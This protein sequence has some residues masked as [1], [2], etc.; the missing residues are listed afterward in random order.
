MS[1]LSKT[2]KKAKKIIKKAAP[3]AVPFPV[4]TH[5]G[6][7]V[8]NIPLIGTKANRAITLGAATAF[9]GGA[10]SA[11]GSSMFGIHTPGTVS[12]GTDWFSGLSG[13]IN[14]AGQFAEGLAN[15]FGQF[16]GGGSPGVNAESP[17]AQG[18]APTEASG[19]SKVMPWLLIGGGLLVVYMLA[20]RR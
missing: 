3:I 16:S 4:T 9:T 6:M 14:K 17:A 12:S 2:A 1:W 11:A 13:T 19:M 15:A 10:L 8:S 20:R 5:H 7:P 18:A